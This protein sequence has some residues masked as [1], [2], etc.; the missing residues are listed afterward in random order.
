MFNSQNYV[1][2]LEAKLKAHGDADAADDPATELRKE[3][4][5]YKESEGVSATYIASLE[6]RLGRADGD[7]VSLRAQ[8]EKFEADLDT[9]DAAISKLQSRVDSM[10]AESEDMR[11]WKE[12]LAEREQRV[13]DL[14]R[15]MEEWEKVRAETG[16]HRQRLA[17]AV[18]DVE[19]TRRSLEA[20]VNGA[21]LPASPTHSTMTITPADSSELTSLR[22]RHQNTL[23]ELDSVSAKYRDALK[24][25]SDL[26]AQIAEAKLHSETSSEVSSSDAGTGRVVLRSPSSG[27]RTV[28]RRETSDSLSSLN[29]PA[30][31]AA[32]PP[33]SRRNFFRHAASSEGLHSRSQ[34]QSLSSE[35]SSAS[36]SRTSW[37]NGDSLLSP[38]TGTFKSIHRQLSQDNGRSPES[39]EK[40]IQ[41]LQQVCNSHNV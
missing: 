29:A 14:E 35:F 27:R 16:L 22:E 30:L 21:N 10:L 25:I 32:P 9:K 34:S 5:K 4:A 20:E 28:S 12:S 31:G 23:S 39:L 37:A 15:Q 13:Q 18:S 36:F 40:E 17:S 6:Q 3:I 38:T 19:T 2:D 8:V 1:R 26:A 24:E 41:S 33:S 7:I 11:Q